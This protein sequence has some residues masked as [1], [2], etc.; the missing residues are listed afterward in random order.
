MKQRARTAQWRKQA[1]K[2]LDV[3][4]DPGRIRWALERR[5]FTDDPD[6]SVPQVRLG[7]L[8]AILKDDQ[9]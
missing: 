2:T 5:A 4:G 8:G 1:A 3:I 7:W 9:Q 6:P